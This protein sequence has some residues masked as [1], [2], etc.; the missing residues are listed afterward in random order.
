MAIPYHSVLQNDLIGVGV[1]QRN[2]KRYFANTLRFTDASKGFGSF[3]QLFGKPL[4]VLLAMV[5]TLLLIACVN[6]ANLLITRA[7]ARQKEIA[8]RLSLGAT[9]GSLI[10]LVMT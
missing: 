4:Y 9:R 2:W 8:I 3:Q 1:P 6:V 7:A 10:R 5:G